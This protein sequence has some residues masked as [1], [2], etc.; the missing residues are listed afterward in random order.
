[1]QSLGK[2]GDDAGLWRTIV[3]IVCTL[4]A[5]ILFMI[6]FRQR[7]GGIVRI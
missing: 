6:I 5:L 4:A 7:I 3:I 2:K 1:M